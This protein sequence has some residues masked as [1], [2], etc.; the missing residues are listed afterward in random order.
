[1]TEIISYLNGQILTNNQSNLKF[2]WLLKLRT[3]LRYVS[4]K[5]KM[6]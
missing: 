2:N 4:T 3:S 5:R 6:E 1:M